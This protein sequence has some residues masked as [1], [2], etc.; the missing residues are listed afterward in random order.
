MK[1][2]VP[3]LLIILISSSS[4]CQ[5]KEMEEA[6]SHL[7]DFF[8][9]NALSNNSKAVKSLLKAKFIADEQLNNFQE[10]DAKSWFIFGNIYY[11]IS[12]NQAMEFEFM[13]DEAT[14]TSLDALTQ[15]LNTIDDIPLKNEAVHQMVSV[16]LV[17]AN[18]GYRAYNKGD[19]R[20]ALY[21]LEES[22]KA[23]KLAQKYS[24]MNYNL[25]NEISTSFYAAYYMNDYGKMLTNG[26]ELHLMGEAD[27]F[28]YGLLTTLYIRFGFY[29]EGMSIIAKARTLYPDDKNLLFNELSLSVNSGNFENATNI[30]KKAE[31]HFINDINKLKDIYCFQGIIACNQGKGEEGFE[32]FHKSIQ[33]D[34]QYAFPYYQMAHYYIQTGKETENK[35][36]AKDEYKKALPYIEK[37]FKLE[38]KNADIKNCLKYVY[39]QLDLTKMAEVL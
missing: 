8:N 35:D 10:T 21:K 30:A 13:R 18:Q 5:L 23:K 28:I 22:I 3:F 32:L 19:Y 37:A 4:Y 33:L 24:K 27:E 26:N 11:Y 34:S 2:F 1:A 17:L 38:P 36:Q 31:E 29:D 15:C 9:S 7:N 16:A 20:T 6:N 25:V 14:H 39:T 12:T